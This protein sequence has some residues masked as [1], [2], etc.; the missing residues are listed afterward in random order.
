MSSFQEI[1]NDLYY[2][3]VPLQ[4][5]LKPHPKANDGFGRN[6]F[7]RGDLYT[8]DISMHLPVLE[9]Y[10]SLCD[11]V[12]EFGVRFGVSTIALLAGARK[13]VTSYDY[14]PTPAV[15]YLKQLDLPCQWEFSTES[16][17]SVEIQPTQFLFIDTEHTGTQVRAE[18]HKHHDKITAG[19]Y[20][21]FHDT[22]ANKHDD[23]YTGEILRFLKDNNYK[24][25]YLTEANNGLIIAQ[26]PNV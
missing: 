10:A 7:D 2:C 23:N 1:K 17:L 11:Y 16:T 21:G 12:T 9:Y 22:Y 8:C 19:G 15:E 18:L 5:W 3:S 26:K 6:P 4:R 20:V 13:K 14:Q 25:V 24:I